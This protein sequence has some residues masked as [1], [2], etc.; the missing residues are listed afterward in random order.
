MNFCQVLSNAL[1]IS[2]PF[3]GGSISP[4]SRQIG[5]IIL[6]Q[7]HRFSGIVGSQY[8]E[9]SRNANELQNEQPEKVE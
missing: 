3:K 1:N 6:Q 4:F 5:K 7:K 2:I 9:H 8:G